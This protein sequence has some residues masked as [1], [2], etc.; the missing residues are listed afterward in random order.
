VGIG[1][2]PFQL[3][4]GEWFLAHLRKAFALI[5]PGAEVIF[6][7]VGAEKEIVLKAGEFAG[8]LRQIRRCST[9]DVLSHS[10]LRGLSEQ[11]STELSI[12]GDLANISLAE[13]VKSTNS[14]RKFPIGLILG[15]D[16]LSK[17]DIAAVRSFLEQ[18][19]GPIAFITGDCRDGAGFEYELFRLWTKNW[20]S[21]FRKRLILRRPNYRSGSLAELVQPVAECEL[22]LSSRFHGLLAGA[23]FGCR[24]AALARSSKVVALA[25]ELGIPYLTPPFRAYDIQRLVTDAACVPRVQL[26]Q[27]RRRAFDGV[28]ACKCW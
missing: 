3:T 8:I 12:G 26:E 22:L 7:N 18:T 21:G 10:I 9:R 23:W 1:D 13:L 20:L 11:M 19:R 25:E 2:T 27:Q 6:V 28:M 5:R 16:T 14:D 4:C 17:E 24:V 15:Y